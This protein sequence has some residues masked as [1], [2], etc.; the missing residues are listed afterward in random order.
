MKIERR[1]IR[2]ANDFWGAPAPYLGGKSKQTTPNYKGVLPTPGSM[3]QLGL[4]GSSSKFIGSVYPPILQKRKKVEIG[5]NI[6]NVLY[7]KLS[8]VKPSLTKPKIIKKKTPPVFDVRSPIKIS[9]GLYGPQKIS[10]SRLKQMNP[11][12]I[13]N[14]NKFKNIKHKDLRWTQAVAN[15]KL[16][17]LNPF[18]DADKDGVLNMFDCRPFDRKRQEDLPNDSTGEFA[19]PASK[20]LGARRITK[21]EF[22]RKKKEVDPEKEA[23]KR[24]TKME[25]EMLEEREPITAY[26]ED[27]DIQ[28]ASFKMKDK[29]RRDKEV[30]TI[31]KEKQAEK[32]RMWQERLDAQTSARL[33][34]EGKKEKK[35]KHRS[36]TTIARIEDRM[37]RRQQSFITKERKAADA[38][39][40][41]EQKNRLALA[42]MEA[43]RGPRKWGTLESF[44]KTKDY[45]INKKDMWG[46]KI[47]EARSKIE[48]SNKSGKKYKELTDQITL[49]KDPEKIK[50]L[51][52]E[53]R[54]IVKTII[55]PEEG[56]RLLTNIEYNKMKKE[57]AE[58][59][60]GKIAEMEAKKQIR[61]MKTT[62]MLEKAGLGWVPGAYS[63]TKERL[64][65]GFQRYKNEAKGKVYANRAK[66][67]L[68][69][70]TSTGGMMGVESNI[71]AGMIPSAS[72][73]YRIGAN[74]EQ[75]SNPFE[76]AAI[77]QEKIDRIN[78]ARAAA[79]AEKQKGAGR[80]FGSF[81]Y[82]MPI[83]EYKQMQRNLA[84]QQM[85]QE[86]M[87]QAQKAAEM[88]AQT[89][90]IM[91]GTATQGPQY[92][93]AT[94][95]SQYQIRQPQVQQ[96]MASSQMVQQQPIYE[97]VVVGEPS[98]ALGG[99]VPQY[100]DQPI[101]LTQ[102]GPMNLAQANKGIVEREWSGLDM[103]IRST[104]NRSMSTTELH[105]M[106][107]IYGTANPD[108][109]YARM[110]SLPV[111]PAMIREDDLP[112]EYYT[113]ET[114]AEQVRLASEQQFRPDFNR[115]DSASLQGDVPL[116][117]AAKKRDLRAPTVK[118]M[119]LQTQN[120]GQR[121]MMPVIK[122]NP[123]GL[124]LKNRINFSENNILESD[125]KGN[126]VSKD[127]IGGQI[128]KAPNV[129][130]NETTFRYNPDRNPSPLG[131]NRN[132]VSTGLASQGAAIRT[133]QASQL[134]QRQ[135]VES[136]QPS[137]FQKL[138]TG[139]P[140]RPPRPIS[141]SVQRQ[142][143]SIMDRI[144]GIV[145][146]AAAPTPQ[147]QP[148]QQ[149]LA[150]EQEYIDQ[151][152]ATQAQSQYQ[153]DNDGNTQE[154]A[155]NMTEE[156]FNS[157]SVEDQQRVIEKSQ[158]SQQASQEQQMSEEE[159]ADL[160]ALQ[161]EQQEARTK[162]YDTNDT[163]TYNTPPPRGVGTQMRSQQPVPGRRGGSGFN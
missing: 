87:A 128:L 123:W 97:S 115:G 1:K 32:Q 116:Q 71:F 59:S 125:L 11:F 64:A 111:D 16:R 22:G 151:S 5:R 17:G 14:K 154:V 153:T 158:Q 73:R 69:E 50:I 29:K 37:D 65:A 137:F 21:E 60:A 44:G 142:R 68:S 2:G 6:F 143:P 155:I 90:A 98:A 100:N 43:T 118:S 129:F 49:E 82:G 94:D 85:I 4:S 36:A 160:Q 81:K 83:Q 13:N 161:Q 28:S 80:P 42:K 20:K 130:K 157:L 101:N 72:S 41:K 76:A 107:N 147:E 93:Q 7:P 86:A 106:P 78:D 47:E 23:R 27:L 62:K 148:V 8:L 55:S 163:G 127:A 119:V 25:D 112:R 140:L 121:K 122:A 48:V 89:D 152:Q 12:L 39:K 52:A 145:G 95:Y 84:R 53:R 45:L 110:P 133:Q 10:Q 26:A 149:S 159:M 132:P 66:G 99:P 70:L 105:A 131:G 146:G 96:P 75:E 124:Q 54:E 33:K 162:N 104:A 34:I 136:Q 58:K 51:K 113:D 38:K 19:G 108:P 46:S 88:Q 103:P 57:K 134:A 67:L 139:Q 79:L 91:A 138:A 92:S 40:E 56:K 102:G 74:V 77:Q 150:D 24:I 117:Y 61:E 120:D 126:V 35:E 144:K 114:Q 18:G 9:A 30:E 141:Q 3:S 156:E 63:A 31:K 15:P 135:R 109:R